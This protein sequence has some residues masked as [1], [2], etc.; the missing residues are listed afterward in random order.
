MSLETKITQAWQ[1]QALWLWLLLPVS[2]LYGLIISIRQQAY[3]LGLAKSYRAPIPIMVIGNITVGG[4]GK[5]P[6]I[7]ALVDYLQQ[8]KVPVGVISR[9]YGGDSAQMPALVTTD[10]LPSVVGDEPSLIVSMTGVPMAVCPNRQQA[11]STLIQA[12]PN[13]QLIIA[14]DGL[15]HYALQRDIEW[16]VVDVAR[17]FGSGQLLPTGF[18]REPMS[19][20]DKATVIYHEKINSHSTANSSQSTERLTMHLQPDSLQAL[21][22]S[23]WSSDADSLCV[24]SQA[25][26]VKPLAGSQVHGVSGIGYPQRFFATLEGL[27]FKVSA[28]PYPDHYD[29]EL[30]DLL[31]YQHY[32]IIITSKDAV[33]IRALLAKVFDTINNDEN[34]QT[35]FDGF[36]KAELAELVA[37]LWVLPVSAELSD[38]CYTKLQR[39]LQGLGIAIKNATY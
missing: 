22:P 16:I 24:T 13:L 28:H 12:H 36:N 19:R 10:S 27:G 3:K 20:L 34:K 31:Q 18:L 9:G 33:K 11:I 15:Q 23:L 35:E 6:L 21:W 5:T 26:G 38:A 2:W 8:H 25:A 4:S 39:Q 32:P 17:G 29:F 1:R 37:R 30:T 7:M 14:D